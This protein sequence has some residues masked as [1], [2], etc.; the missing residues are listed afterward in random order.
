MKKAFYSL[1]LIV[2]TSPS[3]SQ[4]AG[5]I[6]PMDV[7]YGGVDETDITALWDVI[8]TS[9]ETVSF[10]ARRSVIDEVPGSDNRFCWGPICYEPTDNMSFEEEVFLVIL[11]P[12]S[13]SSTFKGY[14]NA[15]GNAGCTVVT[16][17]FFDLEDTSDEICHTVTFAADCVVDVEE[18]EISEEQLGQIGPNPLEGVGT[19][20][21]SLNDI[22]V[23]SKIVFYN[24]VGEQ[25]KEVSLTNPH[26]MVVVNSADFTNG[27]YFYSLVSK[28][29]IVSTKKLVVGS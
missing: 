26:G 2:L 13:I 5:L 20:T 1:L 11:E 12:D 18:E 23:D 4:S 7:V 14:Y 8:N 24:M 15:N 21:Y 28:G 22:D 17:C 6:E 25:V 3:F 27:V 10:R 16:Y 19:F 9:S 29:Q